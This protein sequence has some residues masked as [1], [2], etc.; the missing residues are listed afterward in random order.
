MNEKPKSSSALL[1]LWFVLIGALVGTFVYL[2][3]N[4]K[5]AEKP[6]ED[7]VVAP[8]PKKVGDKPAPTRPRGS[9]TTD[10]ASRPSR[11]PRSLLIEGIVRG[12]TG[13]LVQGARVAVYPPSRPGA[14]RTAGSS[15][16][17]EELKLLNQVV[18]VDVADYAAPRP[19]AQW[20]AGEDGTRSDDRPEAA[21]ETK[22]DGTFSLSVSHG[23]TFRLT[24]SKEGVGQAALNGVSPSPEKIEL[25]LGPGTSVKGL[26]LTD[27]DSV[28]VEA[29]KITFD[30]GQRVFSTLTDSSGHFVADGVTPGQY[31]LTV[32]A[33]GRTPLMENNYRI[34][35]NDPTPITLRM[36]RG[37]LLRVKAILEKEGG[38]VQMPNK[39]REVVGDPIPNADVF[40]MSQDTLAYVR[41]RTNADG[42]VEFPGMPAGTWSIGGLAA[43]LKQFS[44]VQATIDKN[45]LTQD[46]TLSFETAVETVI[47]VRDEDGRPVAGM[48][49][50]GVNADGNFDQVRSAKAGVTDQDGRIKVVFDDAT[51]L[52]FY[53]F[54][55]GYAFVHAEEDYSADEDEP[56]K[57][58]AK[59]KFVRLSGVVKTPE[60][61]PVAGATV[62]VTISPET[63]E[64]L[65][66]NHRTD[67]QG[68]F[69]F[70]T[71]PRTE[72][73]SV[74]ATTDD[75]GWT[76]EDWEVELV[77][78]K[79][80]Y[81]HDFT[82]TPDEF[83][84][85][86]KK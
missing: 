71:L 79:S 19:L 34:H 53:G 39:K 47:E 83:E 50:F 15:A 32:S 52:Y 75:G 14:S 4:T 60:G 20:T 2:Y 72:G 18:Y 46:E 12:P 25:V 55:E 30:N 5:S 11:K 63:T 8:P 70:D 29:A 82:M 68:R 67:A 76:D 57:L 45:Q 23:G 59:R 6:D 86:V 26:V 7:V 35:A 21:T 65:T 77:E 33:K 1:A 42:V 48:E 80:E 74:T 40:A 62:E 84:V 78:G 9:N 43:G 66:L 13:E 10:P 56:L 49:F 73:I 64:F 31:A 17:P 61:K 85:P 58:V 81:S 22:E 69:Q 36:P 44:E 3:L 51:R 16:D 37:T 41:G 38:V 54:K 28:P 27:V 24:A